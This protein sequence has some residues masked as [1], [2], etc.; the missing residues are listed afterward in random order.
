MRRLVLSLAF[1]LLAARPLAAE[2]A[3]QVMA[4]PVARPQLEATW[5]GLSQRGAFPWG[6]AQVWGK[7]TGDRVDMAL[8]YERLS[9]DHKRQALDMLGLGGLPATL[10][11]PGEFERLTQ[12]K[13]MTPY[14]VYA[15]DG[16][17]VS[18]P[19][20]GCTRLYFFTEL[21]RSRLRW[22]GRTPP[23]RKVR[24]PLAEG[25]REGVIA[26]FWQVVGKTQPDI[27]HMAWVPERGHFEIT[28]AMEARLRYR[29]RI[30]GFWWQAPMDLHYVVL[31]A[32]GDW[33]EE[34]GLLPPPFYWNQ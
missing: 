17:I 3:D 31:D 13:P 24:Y 30:V 26:H 8:P 15:H 25:I 1:L 23:A 6:G 14:S 18:L 10:Y 28:V 7:V 34:R 16:R 32:N 5:A 9:A 12:A 22:K 2:C 4:L 33:L 20:D 11:L 21:D 27:L 29:N 19:Y